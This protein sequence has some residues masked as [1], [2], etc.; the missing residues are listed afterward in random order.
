MTESLQRIVARRALEG[1][2]PETAEQVIEWLEAA[3]RGW[4]LNPTPFVWGG[5]RAERRGRARARHLHAL[6]GS[7]ACTQWRPLRYRRTTLE[8]WQRSCQLTH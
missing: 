7:G 8:H 3:V 1:Q 5:A 4:N 2:H 6:A